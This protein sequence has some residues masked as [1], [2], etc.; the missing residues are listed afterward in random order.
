MLITGAEVPQ[1]CRHASLALVLL[2]QVQIPRRATALS[3]THWLGGWLRGKQPTIPS[4][5]RADLIHLAKEMVVRTVSGSRPKLNLA[6]VG[7]EGSNPF[8]RS[9]RHRPKLSP[10]FSD[11]LK[12][13]TAAGF[14]ASGLG[15]RD[16]NERPNLSPTGDLSPKLGGWPIYSTSFFGCDFSRLSSFRIGNIGISFACGSPRWIGKPVEMTPSHSPKVRWEPALV[17]RWPALPGALPC[18]VGPPQVLA[19]LMRGLPEFH[20]ATAIR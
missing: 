6:K 1:D 19:H 4:F 10:R 18:G 2:S 14:C 5:N 8:A 17:V 15:V 12:S 7:V 20:L 16:R 11:P 3:A 9:S 13:P